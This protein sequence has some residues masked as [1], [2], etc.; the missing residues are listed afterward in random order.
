[1]QSSWSAARKL[2][3]SGLIVGDAEDSVGDYH[4]FLWSGGTMQD[5]DSLIPSSLNWNLQYANGINDS[6]QICGVGINPSGQT[7]AFLLTPSPTPEPSTLALLCAG[8]GPGGLQV[9]T[10]ANNGQTRQPVRR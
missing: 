2:N 10:A 1:M 5:L 3:D 8:P 9:A 7:D 4:A 6:G